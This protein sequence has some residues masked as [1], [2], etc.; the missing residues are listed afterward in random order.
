[1][2]T[3]GIQQTLIEVLPVGVWL[4]RRMATREE[5]ETLRDEL[6]EVVRRAP[7][8]TPRMPGGA[9]FNLKMTNCGDYGWVASG[10][11]SFKYQRT[12]IHPEHRGEPWPGIPPTVMEIARRAAREAGHAAYHP[13]VCLINYYEG[14]G[15][16]GHHRDDTKGEVFTEA[17]V[18][19]SLGDTALF[20]IGGIEYADSKRQIEFNSGDVLVM[21]DIGRLYYHSVAKILPRTSDLLT[22]GGRISATLRRVRR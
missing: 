18:T 22:K 3:R 2:K 14:G 21:A 17:I 4:F 11:D 8:V 6:R 10:D 5:Q 12:Q 19:I 7:L 1:M 15:D 13:N 16:L 20:N 9:D